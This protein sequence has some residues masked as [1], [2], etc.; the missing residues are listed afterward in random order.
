MVK[1]NQ[2][3]AESLEEMADRMPQGDQADVLRSAAV[4]YRTFPMRR[5][6]H[7]QEEA[8]DVNQAAARAVR[9]ATEGR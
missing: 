1:D 2:F 5:L 8:E 6:I 3:V 9:E 4:I 7:V